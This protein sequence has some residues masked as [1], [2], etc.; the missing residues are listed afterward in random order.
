[1]HPNQVYHTADAQRNLDF[2]RKRAFGVLAVSGEEGPVISYIPF[3][4]LE[5]GETL[6]WHLVR[7]N[8]IARML[9]TPLNAK[10]AI[11]GGDAISLQIGMKSM[12]KCPHG[13]MLRSI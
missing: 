4:L 9:K 2:A 8:P 3:F 11:S 10:I 7:S 6:D 12:T 13:T 5:E 1:M